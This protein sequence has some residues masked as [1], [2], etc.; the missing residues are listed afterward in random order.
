MPCGPSAWWLPVSLV[1]L[2]QSLGSL[3]TSEWQESE[4]QAPFLGPQLIFLVDGDNS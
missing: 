1:S 4:A 2:P 3:L